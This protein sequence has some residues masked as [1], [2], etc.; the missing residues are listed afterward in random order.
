MLSCFRQNVC[1]ELGFRHRVQE[2]SCTKHLLRFSPS[3][4]VHQGD[5]KMKL[6][7]ATYS[8]EN[9]AATRKRLRALAVLFNATG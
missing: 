4:M 6:L 2:L 7:L 9:G 8:L 1:S 3:L 5:A